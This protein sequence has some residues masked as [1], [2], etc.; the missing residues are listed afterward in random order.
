MNS[1]IPVFQ[2]GFKSKDI[3]EDV[4]PLCKLNKPIIDKVFPNPEHVMGKFMLH[5]FH[6][7]I[8]ETVATQLYDRNNSD[9]LNPRKFLTNLSH[10][11]LQTKRVARQL[12]DF[13]VGT[14]TQF[15]EQITEQ[16]YR[17]HM[18]NYI[19]LEIQCLL[20]ESS[21]ILQMYY[22]FLGHHKRNIQSR[23][24]D[25]RTSLFCIVCKGLKN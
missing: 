25:S 16:I 5:I 8:Q 24:H 19:S 6:G 11:Y 15:L 7:R 13:D 10:L 4:L 18:D 3:F 17:K 23:Y 21:R 2:G 1:H 14:D 20:H 9:K 22:E 12:K